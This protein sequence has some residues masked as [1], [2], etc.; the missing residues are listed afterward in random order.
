MVWHV[1]PLGVMVS[2]SVQLV[3]LR[4]H[5]SSTTLTLRDF[6]ESASGEDLCSKSRG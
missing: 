1:I 4:N 6:V 2:F 5:L 3:Q